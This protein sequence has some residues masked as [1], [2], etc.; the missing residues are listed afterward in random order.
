[1]YSSLLFSTDPPPPRSCSDVLTLRPAARDGEYWLYPDESSFG[2]CPTPVYCHNMN[3]TT[4][5][6]FISLVS[7]NAGDYPL[8]SKYYCSTELNYILS[9]DNS[10]TGY[11]TFTKIRVIAE[12]S[13]LLLFNTRGAGLSSSPGSDS[14]DV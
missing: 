4:P 5:T 8:K 11:T 14:N 3:S 10:L 7:L 12:V 1:M 6:E 13:L 9:G 2:G